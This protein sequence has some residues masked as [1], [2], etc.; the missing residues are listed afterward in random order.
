MSLVRMRS[1]GAARGTTVAS[2]GSVYPR[3]PAGHRRHGCPAGWLR[4]RRQPAG[5]ARGYLPTVLVT[6]HL[7]D[8]HRIGSHKPVLPRRAEPGRHRAV[9]A[10][11]RHQRPAHR[12]SAR[13]RGSFA[14]G[15]A[16]LPFRAGDFLRSERPVLGF[17]RARVRSRAAD[18]A[19]PVMSW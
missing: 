3:H 10:V 15:Q 11:H 9:V 6:P 2:I 4:A 1:P 8:H 12:E 7:S 19:R 5:A 17:G 16:E 18:G 14:R 13:S